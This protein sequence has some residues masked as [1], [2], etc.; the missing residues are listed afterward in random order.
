MNVMPL[1]WHKMLGVNKCDSL[2]SSSWVSTHDHDLE[3]VTKVSR[4]FASLSVIRTLWTA[5]GSKL[6]VGSAVW[7]VCVA[8]FFFFFSPL[9]SPNA[10]GLH[11]IHELI[12]KWGKRHAAHQI[13]APKPSCGAFTA[14]A[15]KTAIK[16]VGETKGLGSIAPKAHRHG[17]MDVFLKR[18]HLEGCAS[19]ISFT[20]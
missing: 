4:V 6:P 2:N 8:F 13:S 16:N 19:G 20:L 17:L 11:Q 1:H 15:Q 12:V 9:T 14:C 5:I 18:W 7:W 3:I 10:R